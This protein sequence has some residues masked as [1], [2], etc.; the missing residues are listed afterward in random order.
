MKKAIVTGAN[1]F[2][3]RNLVNKLIEEEYKVCAVVRKLP[4]DIVC[5][6][7]RLEIVECLL[8]SID[9]LPELIDGKW[10]I[11]FHLAW[12]GVSNQDAHAYSVQLDNVKFAC[13]SVH[14]AYEMGCSKYV[15]ASSIMEFEVSELMKTTLNAGMRNIYSTSKISASYM[16]RILANNYKMDYCSTII[17]NVYGPEEFSDRFIIRSL[18]NMVNNIPMNFSSGVQ[19]YDFIYIDNACELLC[20]IGE[21]G[22]NNRRYYIGSKD[23][24]PLR[25]FIEKMQKIAN[26]DY[27]LTFGGGEYVGVSIDYGIFDDYTTDKLGKI[28]YTD[29]EEGIRKTVEWIKKVQKDEK[30]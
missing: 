9:K 18:R 17:S 24:Q 13:D 23:V 30:N 4:S 29:F 11:F 14:A 10:D 27:E 1:G 21:K 16:T 26:K 7:D 25:T 8:S 22:E 28:I 12:Q 19:L 15:F 6:S 5:N 2:I 3:G 20:V